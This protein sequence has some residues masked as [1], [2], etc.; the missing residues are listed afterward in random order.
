MNKEN[1]KK[2]GSDLIINIQDNVEKLAALAHA[3][4]AYGYCMLQNE[5]QKHLTHNDPDEY[6]NYMSFEVTVFTNDTLLKI[7]AD[8]E[9][10]LGEDSNRLVGI[11]DA[12]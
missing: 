6:D 9:A 10:K 11:I 2:E 5:K 8:Y 7:V 12:L 1:L 3:I 4:N